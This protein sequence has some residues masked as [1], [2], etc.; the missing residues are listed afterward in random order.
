MQIQRRDLTCFYH[1]FLHFDSAHPLPVFHWNSN[2]QLLDF[3]KIPLQFHRVSPCNV[4]ICTVYIVQ[5]TLSWSKE[6]CRW[7]W[8]W[9]IPGTSC[10]YKAW[11]IKHELKSHPAMKHSTECISTAVVFAMRHF[12]SSFTSSLD[13]WGCELWYN[14][15]INPCCWS[16]S[17]HN[18][19]VSLE[20]PFRKCLTPSEDENGE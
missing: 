1:F 13:R 15:D 7:W 3:S 4:Y 14:R 11:I 6:L 18:L 12:N 17:T 10:K 5:G 16:F 2:L 9:E 8:W 19:N 20:I